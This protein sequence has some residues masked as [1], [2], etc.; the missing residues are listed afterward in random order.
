MPAG[1]LDG[2]VVDAPADRHERFRTAMGHE[3]ARVT[4]R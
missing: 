3:G 2:I 1:A 4:F